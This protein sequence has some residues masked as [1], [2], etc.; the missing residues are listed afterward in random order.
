MSVVLV[1]LEPAHRAAHAED[2]EA[3]M[4]SNLAARISSDDSIRTTAYGDAR[5]SG[6]LSHDETG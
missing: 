1:R 6:D 3:V 5:P 2:N 4:A